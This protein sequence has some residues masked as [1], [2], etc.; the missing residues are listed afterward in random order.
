MAITIVFDK[1]PNFS[2]P[3]DVAIYKCGLTEKEYTEHMVSSN[4]VNCDFV[5]VLEFKDKEKFPEIVSSI[6]S[7]TI[8]LIF[9]DG[10]LNVLHSVKAPSNSALH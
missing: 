5:T 2:Q 1:Q 8:I 4:P 3:D 10:S 7:P 6:V 9:S